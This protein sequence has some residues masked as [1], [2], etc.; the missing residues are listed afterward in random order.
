VR[1]I[2]APP[3]IPL[4]FSPPGNAVPPWMST[5]RLRTKSSG[6]QVPRSRL[7]MACADRRVDA[8]QEEFHDE[9]RSPDTVVE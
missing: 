6:R 9:E 4:A 3:G 5:E 1:T 7:A 8:A 2:I